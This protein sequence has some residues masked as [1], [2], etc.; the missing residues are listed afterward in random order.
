MPSVSAPSNALV[1]GAN[2]YLG[3]WLVR[4][5]IEHGYRVRGTVRTQSKGEILRESLGELGN[6]F[7]YIIVGDVLKEGAFDDA[8]QGMDIIMHTLSPLFQSNEPDMI[9]P[10]AVAGTIGLLKSA[11]KHQNTIRRVVITGSICA[12]LSWP[13]DEP[14]VYEETSVNETSV[15][16]VEQG[17]V[18]PIAI[19]CA[20]KTHSEK[21]AWAYMQE[22]NITGFDVVY[23][24][25][26]F[27]FGPYSHPVSSIA[28]FG[29]SVHRLHTIVTQGRLQNALLESGTGWI[30]VRD[31]ALAHV[32]AGQKDEAGGQRILIS[33]G[34]C[35]VADLNKMAHSIDPSLP[36]STI[37]VRSD[38]LYMFDTSKMRRVL[39]LE[40]RS[41]EE[42]IRDS[43]AFFRTVPGSGMKQSSINS[44]TRVV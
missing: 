2:G 30:D 3:A 6:K 37:G 19:Y 13:T 18:D 31:I 42:T 1:T 16:V 27:F 44:H 14:R 43:L 41:L 5:L 40:P 35:V 33:A 20:A 39:G 7:E 21:R 32:L 26:S 25:G 34:N 4:I 29:E 23:L 22:Q 8:V 24:H 10:P 36:E 11:Q 17:S 9:I 15:Q 38:N 12:V 28:D